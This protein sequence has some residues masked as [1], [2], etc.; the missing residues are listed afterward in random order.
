MTILYAP[1]FRGSGPKSA[2][3]D[4]DRLDYAALHAVAVEKDATVIIKMHPFVTEPL[5]IPEPFRDRLIDGSKARIDVN[6][7]LF[8]VDLLITD[9]SSIVFE[10]STL[11]RPMLFYAYDLDDYIG[12]RDFYVPFERFV[13]G[14]IVR[15]FPELRRRHPAR[16]LRGREGRRVRR[17]A[18]RLPR[19]RILR[20]GHRPARPAP[21]SPSSVRIESVGW[22]RPQFVVR[23]RDDDGGGAAPAGAAAFA[24]VRAD[25]PTVVMPPTGWRHD[26]D[27]GALVLRFNIVVG[28]GVRPLDP[29]RWLLVRRDDADAPDRPVAA[30]D[31]AGLAAADRAFATPRGTY[32]VTPAAEPSTGGLVLDVALETSGRRPGVVARAAAGLRSAGWTFAFG[33]MKLIA[34]RSGRRVLFV[35]GSPTALPGNLR[36]VH[37]RM[38]ERG[39]GRGVARSGRCF[40]VRRGRRPGAS[41]WRRAGRSPAPTSSSSTARGSVSSTSFAST[42]M[43]GSSSCG[44]GPGHSRPSTTAGSACRT[45]RIPG[46]SGTGTTPTSSSCPMR[47]FRSTPKPS[48]SRRNGSIPTGIPRMDRF[49]DERTR[50]AGLAAARAAYPETEGRMTILFAPTYRDAPAP[51]NGQYPLELLDYEA[52]HALAVEKDAVVIIRMHPFARTDLRIPERLRDRLLD[53]FRSSIDVNDLLFA[54]DLLITDYSSIVFEYLDPRPADAV[55]RLRPRGVHRDA[56]PLRAVRGVR[57]GPDRPD[58]PRAA[59]TPSGATTTRSRRS[60]TSSPATSPTSTAARPTASSTSSS[61]A[62]RNDERPRPDH[63]DRPRPGRVRVRPLPPAPAAGRPRH[64]PRGRARGQPVHPPRRARL[65]PSRRPGRDP[66]PPTGQRCPRQAHGGL[67]RGRRRVLSRHLARLHR[68][69]LLLPDLRHPAAPRD[70][71]HPDLARLR[72]VQEDRLQRARQVVRDGRRAGPARSRPLELRRLPDRLTGGRGAL[73][74]GVPPAAR[75]LPVGPRHPADGRAL[76]RGAPRPDARGGPR[77]LRP[78]TTAAGS[79]CTPR[80]SG[81]TASPTPARPTTSTSASFEPRSATTT[82]CSSG[83][84]RSSARGR[85][86]ARTSPVSPSTYRTTRTSTS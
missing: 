50:A 18:L 63:P 61:S 55:L 49:F 10:F 45:G 64:G 29:G 11:G 26:A 22:E 8:A 81:A 62:G 40:G 1:T 83:S 25:R 27:T 65:A 68:R 12:S 85:S 53:G 17:G 36:L 72:G 74:R 80:H 86:S 51:R 77:P 19:C 38:I 16:R 39:L 37:D 6:D 52:L 3:F 67:A 7:L 47:T 60:P 44:T 28:P 73:R 21:M 9:Y 43:S 41:T 75:A 54:V 59:S 13:P 34:R 42:R 32:R 79:S 76:R 69:R 15:T 31:A 57:A 35:T 30:P 70:D 23:L 56:R 78:A 5:R 58:V 46:R 71:H 84:T 33:A 14:R 4:F 82:S 48:A 24:L 2:T 66:R 20:P